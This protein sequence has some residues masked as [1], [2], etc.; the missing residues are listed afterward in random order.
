MKYESRQNLHL[1]EGILKLRVFTMRYLFYAIVALIALTGGD[2]DSHGLCSLFVIRF[3][4]E[5]PKLRSQI[6]HVSYE[7]FNVEKLEKLSRSEFFEKLGGDFRGHPP[8][9]DFS[10]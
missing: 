10:T 3:R 7:G 2:Y 5:T 9:P 1:R 8:R 4:I 6:S